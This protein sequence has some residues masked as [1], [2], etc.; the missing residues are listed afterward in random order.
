[1]T[2]PKVTAMI[3]GLFP[4]LS[5]HGFTVTS[6]RDTRYNCIA[7]AAGDVTHWWQ[8]G[9][10]GQAIGGY[11]WPTL[12]TATTPEAC[13]RAFATLGYE[14]CANGDYETEYEKVAIYADADGQYTHAARQL[15]NGTW[16]SKLGPSQDIN[17]NDVEGVCGKDYGEVAFFM[18]RPTKVE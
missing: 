17:H 14:R 15:R 3:A 16:V 6:P 12:N 9:V 8:P 13:E 4:R 2:D 7:F 18:R 1:M 10:G 5:E 11:Y